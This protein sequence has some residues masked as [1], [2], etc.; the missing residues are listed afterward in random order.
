MQGHFPGRL[1]CQGTCPMQVQTGKEELIFV[2]CSFNSKKKQEKARLVVSSYLTGD[3]LRKVA[4][5]RRHNK[6]F[7]YRTFAPR[8]AK[9]SG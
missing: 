6:T 3:W 5:I 9:F 7:F 8:E 4:V 2:Y 1:R